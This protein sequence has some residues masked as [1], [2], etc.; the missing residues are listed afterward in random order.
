MERVK[1][2]LTRHY[3]RDPIAFLFEMIGMMFTIAGSAIMAITA[4]DPNMAIIY[5][6][7]LV[8]SITGFVAYT[9]L[10]MIWTIV[11]TGYFI[12]INTIGLIVVFS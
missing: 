1:S 8:G 9:R 5:P 6:L 11:L 2:A 4:K 10:E 12:I 3:N 7:F